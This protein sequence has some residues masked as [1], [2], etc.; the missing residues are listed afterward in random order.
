MLQDGKSELEGIVEHLQGKIWYVM[1]I[2]SSSALLTGI[3]DSEMFLQM[4]SMSLI[5]LSTV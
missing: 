4:V 2:S 1:L 3:F 5:A